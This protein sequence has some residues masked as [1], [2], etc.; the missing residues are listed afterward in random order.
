[1]KNPISGGTERTSQPEESERRVGNCKLSSREN[2]MGGVE[3]L[4]Y[5]YILL[6][7][8]L[9]TLSPSFSHE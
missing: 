7:Y 6:L 8:Y 4:A 2:K 9:L 5:H 3:L 1:V